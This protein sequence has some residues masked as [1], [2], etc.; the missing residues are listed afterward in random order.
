[1]LESIISKGDVHESDNTHRAD[2]E[3]AAREI[4][5]LLEPLAYLVSRP[6]HTND[7]PQDDSIA[8][9]HR[10]AWFNIVAHGIIP[11]SSMGQQNSKE[12]QSIALQS[13]SLVAEDHADQLES[14]IEL[15][16]VLRRSMNGPHT[17]EQKR[18]LISL[19]PGCESNIRSLSYSKVIFLSAVYL[20]ETHRAAGGDCTHI[21]TYFL[22]PNLNGSA[23]ENCMIKILDDVMG[24]YIRRTLN[25]RHQENSASLVA[26]QL[27]SMLTGC[28][29][30]VPRVQQIAASSADKIIRQLPSSLCQ[31]SSLFALLELLT[32]LWMSCLEAELDEYELK[33]KYISVRGEVEVEL[34]DNYDFRR[35]TLNAFYA[36]ARVWV[37]AVVD[38]APLDVKGL[39]QVSHCRCRRIHEAYRI[40]DLLIRIRR[41][42]RLWSCFPWQKLCGGDGFR[43]SF[44]GSETRYVELYRV[45]KLAY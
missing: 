39:L 7:L 29:H 22:D 11:K 35:S 34:S 18:S 37:I 32:I 25:D 38:V 31:K 8:R 30:R 9:L 21:L 4:V 36:R 12:L 41:R 24:I 20:V 27:A 10:E 44:D 5:E 28:C 16:T 40:I 19:L 13:R 1:M 3:L 42:W 14:E 6:R 33:S 15:N 17:A 26:K 43:D 23:M 2:V 45:F